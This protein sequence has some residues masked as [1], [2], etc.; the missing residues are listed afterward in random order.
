ML[1]TKYLFPSAQ[2]LIAERNAFVVSFEGHVDF[3]EVSHGVE[4]LGMVGA[5]L[6]VLGI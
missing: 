6:G 5:E 1:E 4:R 2:E 3:G